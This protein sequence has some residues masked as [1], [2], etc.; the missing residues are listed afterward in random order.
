MFVC[1]LVCTLVLSFGVIE[2][3]ELSCFQRR[4]VSFVVLGVTVVGFVVVVVSCDA[5]ISRDF[6]EGREL[7]LYLERVFVKKKKKKKKSVR[8]DLSTCWRSR[9][10]FA[11]Q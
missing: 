11:S 2:G 3:K 1:E 4:I 10:Y 6:F 7:S 9:R 8:T 5:G